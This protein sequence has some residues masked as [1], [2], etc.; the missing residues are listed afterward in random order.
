MKRATPHERISRAAEIDTVTVHDLGDRML[1]SQ[2]FHVNT[3]A[4]SIG[5]G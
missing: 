5:H 3:E 2:C 4:F 1:L